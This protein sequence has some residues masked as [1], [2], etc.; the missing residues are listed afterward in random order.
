MQIYI[1]IIN[2]RGVLNI[3]GDE[4]AN[5]VEV[6]GDKIDFDARY[7]VG[8]MSQIVFLWE[9][10]YIDNT[11]LDGVEFRVRVVNDKNEE[12]VICGRN[13]FPE[14]YDEFENLIGEVIGKWKSK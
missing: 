1:K 8:K 6:N 5:L 9:D 4:N 13:A 10:K 11:M 2:Q 7:F 14:N 12:R 3:K